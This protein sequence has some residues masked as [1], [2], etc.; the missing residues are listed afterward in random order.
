MKPVENILKIKRDQEA[1]VG[2]W[3]PRGLKVG[4]GFPNGC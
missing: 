3:D 1:G 2:P 4:G